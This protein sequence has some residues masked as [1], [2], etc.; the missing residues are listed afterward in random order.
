LNFEESDYA[1]IRDEHTVTRFA[2]FG[3]RWCT[4]QNRWKPV[5]R[6]MATRELAFEQLAKVRA[7]HPSHRP[8][9]FR[10]VQ[11]DRIHRTTELK[12]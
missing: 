7:D 9:D 6:T 12:E 11:I 5:T 10:V 8:E 2:V 4:T 3:W 1:S